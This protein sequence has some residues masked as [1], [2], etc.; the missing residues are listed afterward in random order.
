MDIQVLLH[1]R[2]NRWRNNTKAI[3]YTHR[4]LITGL[5]IPECYIGFVSLNFLSVTL[6]NKTVRHWQKKS[7]SY[8]PPSCTFYSWIAHICEAPPGGSMWQWYV[9]WTSKYIRTNMD[10][11]HCVHN[12][13]W[14][15]FWKAPGSPIAPL[16]THQKILL[17]G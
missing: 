14:L 2:I 4:S 8:G 17:C 5:V 16:C 7:Q 13:A 10:N 1:V 9:T 12:F 3:N 15:F 11:G 6:S